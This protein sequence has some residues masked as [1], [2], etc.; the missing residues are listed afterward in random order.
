MTY[1]FVIVDIAFL[2]DTL[3]GQKQG[4]VGHEGAKEAVVSPPR[5]HSRRPGVEP[6][7]GGEVTAGGANWT[8]IT[9]GTFQMGSPPDELGR[10]AEEILHPVALPRDFWM[11]TTEITRQLFEEAVNYDPSIS[12]VFPRPE[13]PVE[14]VTW[15]EVAAVA[16]TLSEAEGLATCYSCT[17]EAEATACEVNR[18]FATP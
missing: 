8:C 14:N 7:D 5:P 4:L 9:A 10:S 6:H 18:S 3:V 11:M 16:N 2:R 1:S 12:S 17:G 13:H 15:H